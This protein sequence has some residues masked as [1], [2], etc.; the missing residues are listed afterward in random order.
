MSE[1]KPYKRR[2]DGSRLPDVTFDVE[3]NDGTASMT[4][5]HLRYHELAGLNH[6]LIGE[7]SDKADPT[8]VEQLKER[9]LKLAKVLVAVDTG[10]DD[11][12][13]P[14]RNADEK[15][16]ARYLALDGNEN[17]TWLAWPAYLGALEGATPKS[18]TTGDSGGADDGGGAAEPDDGPHA[19]MSG[20]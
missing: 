1:R 5:R 18:S 6:A 11:D 19:F 17:L 20:V 15:A 12:D 4:A 8:G 10:D 7:V 14:D 2:K 9:R 16:W 13:A 3:T